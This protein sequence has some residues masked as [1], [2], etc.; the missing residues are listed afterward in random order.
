MSRTVVCL[1]RCVLRWRAFSLR[2]YV[3]IYELRDVV[4]M[5]FEGGWSGGALGRIGRLT[6]D[7]M[8]KVGKGKGRRDLSLR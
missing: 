6:V 4:W 2:L 1:S 3:R 7:G 8:A 5:F